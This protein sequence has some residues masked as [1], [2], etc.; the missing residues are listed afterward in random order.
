MPV[1]CLGN[2]RCMA[3]VAH[4]LTVSLQA[5]WDAFCRDPAVMGGVCAATNEC[6][7]FGEGYMYAHVLLQTQCFLAAPE[8]CNTS[9]DSSK[10]CWALDYLGRAEVRGDLCI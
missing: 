3:P 5:R 2:M 1:D 4:H 9:G 6:C 8:S 10:P 7:R